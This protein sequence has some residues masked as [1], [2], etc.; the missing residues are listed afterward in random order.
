[1]G[2][3]PAR[4]HCFDHGRC[5]IFE[6]QA[7]YRSPNLGLHVVECQFFTGRQV[8]HSDI[9][10]LPPSAD[11]LL[12]MSLHNFQFR[13][14]RNRLG[15]GRLNRCMLSFPD[16]LHARRQSL[17]D[18]LIIHPAMEFILLHE[19]PCLFDDRFTTICTCLENSNMP[20]IFRKL[21]YPSWQVMTPT[22]VVFRFV[23]MVPHQEIHG[24][25]Y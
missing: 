5:T 15:G 6:L 14:L 4:A 17:V 13:A 20:C 24:S 19:C 10:P 25:T 1:M 3:W 18:V 2:P 12:S 21:R 16:R 11:P 9:P 23:R 8:A 22:C 7:A